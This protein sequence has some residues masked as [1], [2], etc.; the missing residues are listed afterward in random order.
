MKVVAR[1]SKGPKRLGAEG[2]RVEDY[3]VVATSRTSQGQCRISGRSE[4]EA[5]EEEEEEGEGE[6]GWLGADC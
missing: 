6:G 4:V 3:A 2:G 5:D 1:Q